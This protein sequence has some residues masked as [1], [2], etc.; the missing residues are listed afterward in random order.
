MEFCCSVCS[1]TSVLFVLVVYMEVV[2]DPSIVNDRIKAFLDDPHWPEHIND[3][4]LIMIIIIF[5]ILIVN[6]NCFWI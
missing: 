6:Y 5:E 1:V 4:Q 2:S 3:P